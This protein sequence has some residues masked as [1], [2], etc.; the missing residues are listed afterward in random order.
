MR[1]CAACRACCG[2]FPSSAIRDFQVLL[3]D[4]LLAPAAFAFSLVGVSFA[5][6]DATRSTADLS[7]VLA[8]QIAPSLM[9]TLVGGVIADRIRAAAGDHRGQP[10][11]RPGRGRVRHPGPGRSPAAVADDRAGDL[12]GTGMAIFYPAS[13]RCCRG[14]CPAALLQQASAISRLAMNGGQ[15]GG[16]VAGRPR[17]SRPSGPGWALVVC[18]AGMLGTVPLH[19]APAG[20]GARA[21]RRQRHAARP[22][23]RLGRVPLAHLAVGDRGP[24]RRD[25][26][27]LVR[28]RSRC[29]GRWWPA[30][31]WAA[32]RPG[33]R[34]PRPSRSG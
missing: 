21:D 12:T 29:S 18:G 13:R 15:M 28:R 32:R 26:D 30:R 3:A 31:T 25:P 33:A 23:R 16:A 10:D 8:A 19:A 14:W 4:R 7:Y 17:P 22:A 27:G 2:V 20:G 5:V 6:L 1:P 11:D 24:V 9:F 34:S